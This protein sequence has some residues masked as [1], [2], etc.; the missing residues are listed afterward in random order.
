MLFTDELQN[1]LVCVCDALA[2]SAIKKLSLQILI[3]KRCI[4]WEQ[5]I[6]SLKSFQTSDWCILQF[7]LSGAERADEHDSSECVKF[8]FALFLWKVFMWMHSVLS[9]S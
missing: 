4:S 5:I 8:T 7:G 3:A 1:P 9:P 6:S 2:I